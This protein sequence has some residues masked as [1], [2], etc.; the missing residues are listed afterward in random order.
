MS[1]N[2]LKYVT[3]VIMGR[4]VSFHEEELPELLRDPTATLWPWGETGE[5]EG[6]D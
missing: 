1:E 2:S 3:S 4:T 6:D 5:D